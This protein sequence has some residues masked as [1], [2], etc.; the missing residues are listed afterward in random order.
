MLLGP[1][2]SL[3]VENVTIPL[4][5]IFLACAGGEEVIR[6][7]GQM[8]LCIFLKVVQTAKLP[9]KRIFSH[10]FTLCGEQQLLLATVSFL[11]KLGKF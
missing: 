2:I 5:R 3:P 9:Q 1:L 11:I 8:L 7:L 10:G 4:E 6:I